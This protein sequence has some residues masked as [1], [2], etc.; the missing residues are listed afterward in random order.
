MRSTCVRW[1][2]RSGTC[3]R[4][5]RTS[6][7]S[8]ARTPR[9]SGSTASCS[10]EEYKLRHE[11]LSDVEMQP[12]RP[13][14]AAREPAAAPARPGRGPRLG[15]RSSSCAGSSPRLLPRQQRRATTATTRR[16]RRRRDDLDDDD[17][18]RTSTTRGPRRPRPARAPRAGAA[19]RGPP[20]PPADRP[21][22]AGLRLP[23]AAPT[24]GPSSTAGSCRPARAS[25]PT[26]RKRF[27]LLLGNS[28]ARLRI[29]GRTRSVAPTG[30]ILGYEITPPGRVRPLPAGNRPNCG[31]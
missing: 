9:R 30:G 13:P 28:E 8:C 4:A 20:R 31:A 15:R 22:R 17:P 18:R 26:A 3:S 14:G 21:D 7:A 12:I 11:R 25:R 5:P 29:N 23:D 2:T 1:R 10:I 16:A 6:R 27:R 19:G 24:A